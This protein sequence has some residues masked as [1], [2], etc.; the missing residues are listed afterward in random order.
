MQRLPGVAAE[1][2]AHDVAGDDGDVGLVI[3]STVVAD[4]RTRRSPRRRPPPTG[5][6]RPPT[7][8]SP[9]SGRIRHPRCSAA[10]ARTRSNRNAAPPAGCGAGVRR[11][12]RSTAASAAAAPRCRRRPAVPRRRGRCAPSAG[13]LHDHR[14]AGGEVAD[15]AVAEPA[16]AADDIAV[17]G[18][19]ELAARAAHVVAIG[20]GV[21][22]RAGADRSAASR[23]SRRRGRS[24]SSGWIARQISSGTATRRGSSIRRRNSSD[25][26]LYHTPCHSTGR[27]RASRRRW[28]T[29]APGAASGRHSSSTT[30]GSVAC[31]VH[32]AASGSGSRRRPR[33]RPT[34]T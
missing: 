34:V 11:Q 18:D 31:H 20:V 32:A 4:N 28:C 10:R 16:G 6:T 25:F 27:S 14:A 17:L 21:R 7:A 24:G 26:C 5:R 23:V 33:L 30:G 22:A 29:L 1:R 2:A 3:R 12:S 8:A 13:I 9:G 15:A 19:A